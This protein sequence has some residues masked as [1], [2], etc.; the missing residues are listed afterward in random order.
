VTAGPA[1][2]TGRFDLVDL[3]PAQTRVTFSLDLQPKG[4]MR[5]LAGMI[6]KQMHTEVAQLEQLKVDLER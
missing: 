6:T 5:L 1:R 2:P 4:L 3:G